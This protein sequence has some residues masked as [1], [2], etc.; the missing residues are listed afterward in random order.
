MRVWKILTTIVFILITV[1]I[2]FSEIDMAMK[3]TATMLILIYWELVDIS[4]KLGQEEQLMDRPLQNISD[5]DESKIVEVYDNL[6]WYK[7]PLD[8]GWTSYT[9]RALDC[10]HDNVEIYNKD[11][12]Y[13]DDGYTLGVNFSH[14]P[15]ERYDELRPIVK[16][17]GCKIEDDGEVVLHTNKMRFGNPLLNMTLALSTIENYFEFSG[18]KGDYPYK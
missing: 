5:I 14:I 3:I 9:L 11:N 17:Y 15:S 13:S 7:L 2:A 16:W 18:K 10:M 6:V 8:N 12:I 4:E 1:G